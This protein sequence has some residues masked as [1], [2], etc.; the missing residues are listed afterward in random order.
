MIIGGGDIAAKTLYYMS[1][2][3]NTA[4]TN[5]LASGDV[6]WAQIF[7]PS[8]Q[9]AY[10][11]KDKEH[12][13]YWAPAVLSADVMFMNVTKKPFNDPAF[14]QAMNLV[15]DRE[16]H[17]KIA[18]E[19]AIPVIESITGLPQP[20][21]DDFILDEYKDKTVSVDISGAKKILTDAGYT[22]QDNQLIDK[23]GQ[24]V[25]FEISVPQGWTD[26]VTGISLIADEVKAIGVE[27]V[28][29]TPDVDTWYD[30]IAKGNF[31][32]M[33]HWT[34]TA[35]T[36]YDFYSDI[37]DGRFLKAIGDD[38]TY[39]FGR[40][41][42]KNV[43]EALHEYATASDDSARIKALRIIQ[44]AYVNDVP[45][46]AVGARPLTS[47]YNTRKFTGWPDDRDPYVA[48]DPTFQTTSYLLTKL[49]PVNKN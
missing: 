13:K 6:D 36:P 30:D 35:P 37:M 39:N 17:A 8:I 5:A 24:P 19:G 4:L 7:I 15:V 23:D 40:Y 41:D 3:D 12:N 25:K 9:S 10:L 29:K 1:Y 33:L 49:K 46:I 43:T 26:Y 44:E 21:G 32:A 27:A 42:N 45:A 47:E 20:A 38:A 28:V 11:D 18:R 31:D 2:N 22:Y 16:K 48:A 34:D 14:R